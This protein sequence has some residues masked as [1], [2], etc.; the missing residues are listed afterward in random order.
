MCI[1]ECIGVCGC[2]SVCVCEC[3]CDCGCVC[4]YGGAFPDKCVCMRLQYEMYENICEIF[5]RKLSQFIAKQNI[6]S[7]YFLLLIL[8]NTLLFIRLYFIRISRRRKAQKF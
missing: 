2:V 3:V 1:Y 4:V 6:V 7:V 8:H 5:E